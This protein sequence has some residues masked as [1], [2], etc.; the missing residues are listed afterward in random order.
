[1]GTWRDPRNVRHDLEAFANIDDLADAAAAYIAQRARHCVAETGRFTFA[2][3]G[4]RTPRAMFQKL[5]AY[6]VSWREVTIFQVDE[7]VVALGDGDRNLTSLSL[8]LGDLPVEVH[9]MRVDETDLEAAARDYEGLLPDHFDLVHLG[10]G[11]D[12]HTASLVPNDPVLD[13]E[14]R[15]VAVTGPYQGHRRLTLTY[16]AL[17]RASQLLWVVAGANKRTVLFQLLNGDTSIPAGRVTAGASLVMAD[18]RALG[19]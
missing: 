17:A 18:D 5:S 13:E 19:S 1:M 16:R 4:G 11:P 10:L 14:T 8:V 2:V 9:P 15:L 12:G 3:S 7:R 6:D